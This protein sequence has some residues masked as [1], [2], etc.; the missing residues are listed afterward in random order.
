MA[1]NIEGSSSNS[2][3]N[4]IRG[5]KPTALSDNLNN[6]LFKRIYGDRRNNNR[7]GNNGGGGMSPEQIN[8]YDTHVGNQSQRQMEIND[9]LHGHAQEQATLAHTLGE[10]AKTNQ[11]TRDE[12]AKNTAHV[13]GQSEKSLHM[14]RTKDLL[15]HVAG[16]GQN[17]STLGY[18]D[19]NLGF[20]PQV[21]G[22]QQAGVKP[23][24][25]STKTAADRTP[26][27]S[28]NA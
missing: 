19:V 12:T 22:K 5:G 20:H 27:T 2:V 23:S 13:R 1:N 10:S 25:A 6:L 14:D 21:K 9:Q 18:G 7:G 11:F 24:R 15:T 26:P 3:S 17:V 8:A 28:P 16:L 4:S